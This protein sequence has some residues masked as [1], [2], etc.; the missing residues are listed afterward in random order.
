MYKAM[1]SKCVLKDPNHIIY[2]NIGRY[3]KCFQSYKNSL[4]YYQ[5]L[6]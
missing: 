6:K 2:Y 5:H 4:I 1:F 3:Y